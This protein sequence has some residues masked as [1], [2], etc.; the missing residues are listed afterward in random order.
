MEPQTLVAEL[1]ESGMTQTK[2]ADECGCSQATISDIQRGEIKA[3]NWLI[4]DNLRRLHDALA[5]PEESAETGK[6]GA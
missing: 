5:T 4:V 6:V 3:P 2:I 1:V